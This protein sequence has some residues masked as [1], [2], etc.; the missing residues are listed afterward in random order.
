MVNGVICIFPK[1]LIPNHNNIVKLESLQAAGD[2][3]CYLHFG[4]KLTESLLAILL[5]I[6]RQHNI[7]RK[8]NDFRAVN[9]NAIEFLLKL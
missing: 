8:Q 5:E 9:L 2:Q 4:I 1:Q 7:R 3:F 6:P